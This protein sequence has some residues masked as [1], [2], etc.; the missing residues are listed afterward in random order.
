MD[1]AVIGMSTNNTTLLCI[2]RDPTQLSL[3]QD[4]G[5]SLVTATNGE[6]GLQFL[7]SRPVDAVLLDY[8]LG[9]LDGRRIAE[10]IN[11][12]RPT[13]PIVMVTDSLELPDGALKSVEAFATK[14]D[15]SH[16]LLAT[17]DFLLSVKYSTHRAKTS[18]QTMSLRKES[19]V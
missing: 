19:A 12:V 13:V 17:I 15:G 4:S 14:S 1:N 10:Q 5:Y 18:P 16:F 11:Q 2:H 9:V 7:L 6:D 8:Q 3:L